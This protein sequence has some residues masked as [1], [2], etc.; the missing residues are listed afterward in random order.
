VTRAA[1][2]EQ[3]RLRDGDAGRGWRVRLY[4]PTPAKPSTWRLT[5]R[6]P[7]TGATE[8]RSASSYAEG[9]ALMRQTEAALDANI[10]TTTV[11]PDGARRDL[12]SLCA[13]YLTDL[14]LAAASPGYLVK[15]ANLLSTHVVPVAGDVL[16]RDW[17]TRDSQRVIAAAARTCRA[18]RLADLRTA[19]SGLRSTARRER[20]LPAGADPLEGLVTPRRQTHQGEAT[21][22]VPRHRRATTA[23]VEGLVDAA[24]VYG[25]PHRPDLGLM[26]ALLGYTGI[27]PSEL[28]ALDAAQVLDGG[29]GLLVE[30]TWYKPGRGAGSMGPTKNG[31]SRELMVPGSLAGHLGRLTDERPTGPLFPAM[32]SDRWDKAKAYRVIRGMAAVQRSANYTPP[33]GTAPW[34]VRTDAGGELARAGERHLLVLDLPAYALRHHAATWLHE[35]AEVPW[36]QVAELLG[37]SDVSVTLRYY[38]RAGD[39]TRAAAR[40]ALDAL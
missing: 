29:R 12:A 5:Y 16:V 33:D 28:W 19:L 31:L 22:Y 39:D 21:G 30:R 23:Q 2:I 3:G 38:V 15:V 35:V 26:Y 17:G 13:R 40:L 25:G 1:P 10:A 32:S 34:P 20:L 4:G 18:K 14:E 9:L 24:R 6:S 11:T 7:E 37:H 27:R 8:S 36:V